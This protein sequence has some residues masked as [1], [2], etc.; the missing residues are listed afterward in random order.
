MKHPMHIP[1]A[2]L[3][4]VA[5]RAIDPERGKQSVLW[6]GRA[7]WPYPRAWWREWEAHWKP[8]LPTTPG[9]RFASFFP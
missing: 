9:Q 7:V 1:L 8:S 3:L 6:I 2:A 4:H 5:E